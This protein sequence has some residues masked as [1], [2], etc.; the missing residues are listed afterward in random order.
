MK[1]IPTTAP[2]ISKFRIGNFNWGRGEKH[3]VFLFMMV[4]KH[5]ALVCN[6]TPE[7]DKAFRLTDQIAVGLTNRQVKH[8]IF[9][10]YWP[11]VWGDITDVWIIG[12]GTEH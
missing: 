6:P 1:Y 2:A 9:T 4:E 7:A 12:G 5:I 10:V 8:S 11:Q 3:F